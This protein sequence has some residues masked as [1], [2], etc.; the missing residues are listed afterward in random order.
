MESISN[1]NQFPEIK[2]GFIQSSSHG[3]NGAVILQPYYAVC[4]RNS[5][6]VLFSPP[7]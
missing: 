4:A 5:L 7:P 2:D 1:L 6:V 3:G